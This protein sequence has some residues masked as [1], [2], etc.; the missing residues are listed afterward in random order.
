MTIDDT[1]EA[2]NRSTNPCALF[3]K[4]PLAWHDLDADFDV[5]PNPDCSRCQVSQAY[6]ELGHHGRNPLNLYCGWQQRR[7]SLSSAALSR[8]LFIV[9]VVLPGQS[10]APA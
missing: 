2:V 3:L 6:S 9:Q 1:L 8:L 10:L 5:E 4:T 7:A